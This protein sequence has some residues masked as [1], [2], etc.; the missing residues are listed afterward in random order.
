MLPSDKF[1]NNCG[2]SNPNAANTGS[3]AR[4][5]GPAENNGYNQNNNQ[6]GQNY[7]GYNQNNNQYGQNYGGYNQNSNQYGQNYGGYNQ[8]SNQ[9]GQNYG[10]YNRNSNQY[11]Q[12]YGGYNQNYNQYGQGYNGYG[13]VDPEKASRIAA[14]EVISPAYVGFGDAVKLFFKNFTNFSGR[15]TRSEYW[16]VVLFN[17]IVSMAI[18][19]ITAGIMV[20]I[21][22]EI[23]TNVFSLIY[24]VIIAIPGLALAIRR[25]HDIGKSGW[26]Y[27]II[28]TCVGVFVLLYWFCQPSAPANQ[29]GP[30]ANDLYGGQ[31]Y[32]NGGPNN[33]NRF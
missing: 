26:W 32:G 3:P 18:S 10:G 29:Y 13:Y 11:G 33:Y 24:S 30:S 12:N 27:L 17:W 4:I 22:D 14:G 9:Y 6:Y 5:P 8:N 25:L 15:S 28:F 1:C 21:G 19:F 2:A 23:G 31:G 7:G 20:S 16:Y